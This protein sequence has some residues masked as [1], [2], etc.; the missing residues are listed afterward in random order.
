MSVGACA[1]IALFAQRVAD[2]V[3]GPRA[4]AAAIGVTVGAQLGVAPV[5]VPVFGPMPL[6]TLPANLLA[7]PA[8]GPIMVWGMTAGVV[9]GVMPT[10]VAAALHVPTRV[11]ISWVALVARVSAR[12]PLGRV[13]L[14]HLAAAA[15]AVLMLTRVGQRR[16]VAAVVAGVILL[17]PTLTSVVR[18]RPTLTGRELVPGL[19]AWRSDGATVLVV[20]EA[21][22]V[23]AL[24]ALR[25]HRVGR[26]DVV[27]ATSAS[28]TVA[29]LLA[30][31]RAR[32]VTR[33]VLGPG[34][35]PVT[36]G[37]VVTI[38]PLRITVVADAPR[39]EVA[40]CAQRGATV[41]PCS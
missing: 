7:V 41:A 6:A 36:A 33:A 23:A 25:E 28:R 27:V 11:L 4:V 31:I 37:Q 24:A 18:A 3:P 38:G 8:A 40:V 13:T 35:I 17:S 21:R 22:P 16:L 2:R 5:L 9:A 26:A 15:G 39:L 34:G 29:E 14:V 12:L 19:R 20:G 30:A 32:V 10:F 1:G